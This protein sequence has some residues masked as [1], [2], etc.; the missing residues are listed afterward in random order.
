MACGHIVRILQM[1]EE[2]GRSN[3]EKGQI[4]MSTWNLVLHG[5]AQERGEKDGPKDH[6]IQFR[7]LARSCESFLKVESTYGRIISGNL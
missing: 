5:F 3:L 2:R 4:K 7:Y 6:K 1:T